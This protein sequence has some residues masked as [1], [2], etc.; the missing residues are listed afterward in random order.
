MHSG[1]SLGNLSCIRVSLKL[2][3]VPIHSYQTSTDNS[4]S[5]LLQIPWHYRHNLSIS[6]AYILLQFTSSCGIRRGFLIPTKLLLPHNGFSWLE[7]ALYA[8]HLNHLSH[9][10]TSYSSFLSTGS[11]STTMS[12][13]NNMGSA[14]RYANLFSVR[15]HGQLLTTP[16]RRLS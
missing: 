9:T 15:E 16:Q 12:R 2:V 3:T 14:S 5:R 4:R 13:Q 1:F 6:C 8:H 10:H 11:K 7:S